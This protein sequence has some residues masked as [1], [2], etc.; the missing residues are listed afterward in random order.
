MI[1]S[2]LSTDYLLAVNLAASLVL[3]L[4]CAFALNRMDH[5]SNHVVRAWYVITGL[6]SFGVL[7]GP[8]Y[9][10]LH[11]QP[12]EVISNVGVTG[13]MAGGWLYRNRRVTDRRGSE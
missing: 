10:Y 3:F 2:L 13:L 1:K 12:M 8:L 4:H 7:V 9:G 6:G 11:P 5:R